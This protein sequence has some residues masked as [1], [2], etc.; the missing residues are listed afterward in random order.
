MPGFEKLP[1]SKGV[2]VGVQKLYLAT[3][4]DRILCCGTTQSALP[5]LFGVY[6]LYKALEKA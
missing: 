1:S 3:A 5:R 6:A 4:T 2:E